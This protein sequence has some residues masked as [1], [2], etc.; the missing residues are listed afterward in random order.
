MADDFEPEAGRIARMLNH[1]LKTGT[2]LP[3]AE[4]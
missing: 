4:L 1:Y 2:M 3:L